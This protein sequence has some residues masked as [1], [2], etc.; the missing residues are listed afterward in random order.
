[1]EINY[2]GR[3]TDGTVFDSS[4]DRKPLTVK[5]G[6]GEV[7]KGWDIGVMSMKLG[8]VSELTVGPQYGYGWDDKPMIPANSTLIFTLE[9]VKC[10]RHVTKKVASA[11]LEN[12]ELLKN[13]GN[14][15]FKQ[16]NWEK[17]RE[18]YEESIM[19]ILEVDGEGIDKMKVVVLQNLSNACLKSNDWKLC[20]RNADGALKIDPKSVKALFF[21]SQGN[22]KG[23]QYEAAF[24]DAKA[25]VM[26][27]L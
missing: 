21:R 2:E 10:N 3:L 19:H 22:L 6:K 12:S 18:S 25:S 13:D 24:L 4:Y 17:A 23:C 14:S 9:L 15:A 7:I 1:V 8:E 20:I 11:L 5:I 16:G 27:D 26:L